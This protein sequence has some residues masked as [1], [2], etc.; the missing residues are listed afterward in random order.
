MDKTTVDLDLKT[1]G[2]QRVRAEFNPSNGGNVNA[3]K[4]K[5]AELINILESYKTDERY[6]HTGETIRLI[7]LAQTAFEEA[8]MWGVKAVT[9]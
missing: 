7:A 2:E 5:S 3:I 1:I 4:T 6:S 9:G 8:A